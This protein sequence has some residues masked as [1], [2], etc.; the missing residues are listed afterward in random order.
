MKYSDNGWIMFCFQEKINKVTIISQWINLMKHHSM[1]FYN[2]PI[3]TY[4]KAKNGQFVFCVKWIGNN[5]CYTPKHFLW[6]GFK[7]NP[8]FQVRPLLGNGPNFNSIPPYL[9]TISLLFGVCCRLLVAKHFCSIV[10]TSI[11]SFLYCAIPS[12]FHYCI[13]I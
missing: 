2:K 11:L 3:I 10:P 4:S 13:P 6:R 1:D 5:G 8:V 9:S 7:C 12:C